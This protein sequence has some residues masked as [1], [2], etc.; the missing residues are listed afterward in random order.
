MRNSQPYLFF[1]FLLWFF[2]SSAAFA[3][4]ENSFLVISD[5]HLDSAT[6]HKMDISPHQGSVTN[7]LDQATFTLLLAEIAEN[8]KTGVVAPPKFIIL[9]GDIVG[10]SRLTADS[11]LRS[12]KNVFSA[13][14]ENFPTTPIFYIFGNNDS[15]KRNYGPFQDSTN[16][17]L[18]KSP[19]DVAMQQS[20]WADGFL[21]TGIQ[22]EDKENATPCLIT[23]NTT[24]GYY[25]AYLATKLRIIALNSVLFS[26]KR[27][28]VSAEASL[29]QLHWLAEQLKTAQNNQESVL[30]T[31]HVPPGKNVYDGGEF[32]LP[33]EQAIF[34]TLI[35][36]HQANIIGLLASHTHL[37][38]LK[39]IQDVTQQNI[40]GVYLVAA[41]STA[42]G[43]EPSV[44]TFYFA[45]NNAQWFL[46]NYETFHF[47][48]NNLNLVFSKLYD[49]KSYYCAAEQTALLGCL[50]N[51]TAQ[52]MQKY[53][54]AGNP[55][56]VGLM[57]VPTAINIIAE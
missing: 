17:N 9:L 19:Y 28:G 32:W 11:A 34:L 50:E 57:H 33:Q 36:T 51:V 8:I 27:T 23:T 6:T 43:N 10:H 49:Y 24:D 29:Q 30:I 1:I 26:P 46:S 21:S 25:A 3:T 56:Y 37:E 20:G 2:L 31:M 12:E 15:L 18:E 35:K 14:K 16:L 52:K 38:E 53:F 42:H 22:C 40:A 47:S 39:T 41:F 4:A 44:K 48:A 5:I 13:L 55:N 45:K 54:S 7:D